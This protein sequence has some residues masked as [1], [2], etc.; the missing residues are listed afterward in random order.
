[1]TS[2]DLSELIERV[3]AGA[4]QSRINTLAALSDGDSPNGR[5]MLQPDAKDVA[6]RVHIPVMGRSGL[7]SSRPRRDHRD[8]RALCCAGQISRHDRCR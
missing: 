1:M 8:A 4:L 2:P 3:E 6:R 7:R 5:L